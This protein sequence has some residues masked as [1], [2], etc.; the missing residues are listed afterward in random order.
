MTI[1]STSVAKPHQPPIKTLP[2]R[3]HF[4]SRSR[5]KQ[6][7]PPLPIQHAMNQ[8]STRNPTHPDATL[9]PSPLPK[10]HFVRYRSI[11]SALT[12]NI[13]TQIAPI[14]EKQ[15]L[16]AWL[17]QTWR[18]WQARQTTEHCVLSTAKSARLRQLDRRWA[19]RLQRPCGQ[20]PI[21]NCTLFFAISGSGWLWGSVWHSI[22]VL[23]KEMLC[24]SCRFCFI[25]HL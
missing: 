8:Q 16:Y 19:Y 4:N 25:C 3:Q 18:A 12:V 9:S 7:S 2:H 15:R 1:V 5:Q 11:S 14:P 10:T 17:L 21:P 20:G 22:L 13:F 23:F 6:A 24:A